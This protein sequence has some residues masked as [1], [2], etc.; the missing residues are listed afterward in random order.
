MIS[1]SFITIIIIAIIATITVVAI[2]LLNKM[3]KN[4][5][6]A[7]P[8]PV[9][10]CKHAASG[11]CCGG[12]NCERKKKESLIVY[13]EDEELDRF[14]G[15]NAEEY[16]AEEIREFQEVLHTLR[17]EEVAPW[18]KSLKLREINLPSVLIEEAK[19]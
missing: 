11:G 4:S 15:R 5:P 2:V 16:E 3:R 13:F 6:Q 12:V 19:G 10:G 1:V 8:E 18:L 9:P 17:P 7:L 14:K